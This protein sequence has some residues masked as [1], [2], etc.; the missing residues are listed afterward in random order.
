MATAQEK[1]MTWRIIELLLAV[2]VMIATSLS[3][4]CLVQVVGAQKE[5]AKLQVGYAS[6]DSMKEIS[7]NLIMVEVEIK[8]LR[9]N[10]HH[11]QNPPEWLLER[12]RSI[13]TKV[14]NIQSQLNSSTK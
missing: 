6:K 8:N 11:T 14:D 13:E 4:W 2:L 12:L 5:I 1:K 9:E 10:M 3:S 7:D